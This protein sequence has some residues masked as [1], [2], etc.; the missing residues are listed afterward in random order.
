M[1]TCVYEHRCQ[2]TP[3]GKEEKELFIPINHFKNTHTPSSNTCCA[4]LRG[5]GGFW[6]LFIWISCCFRRPPPP[7]VRGALHPYLHSA[8]PTRMNLKSR[9]KAENWKWV[10]GWRNEFEIPGRQ[11]MYLN[12]ITFVA[13]LFFTLPPLYECKTF[14]AVRKWAKND[15]PL[16][17]ISPFHFNLRLISSS[18]QRSIQ[19]RLLA[20]EES[21]GEDRKESLFVIWIIEATTNWIFKF[22]RIPKPMENLSG[23]WRRKFLA[24]NHRLSIDILKRQKG[25]LMMMLLLLLSAL[26]STVVFGPFVRETTQTFSSRSDTEF[27]K[28]MIISAL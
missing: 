18:L 21:R 4:M 27:P 1:N 6:K 17:R 11:W 13:S 5:R 2:R 7:K 8:P 15:V 16:L 20:R 23:F 24:F 9:E 14:A 28:A 3:M 25:G 26:L 22:C 19:C 10:G 12:I